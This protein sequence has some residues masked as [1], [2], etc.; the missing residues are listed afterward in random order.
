[1]PFA[2]RRHAAHTR[3]SL[4]R[5]HR[6]DDH[7]TTKPVSSSTAAPTAGTSAARNMQRGVKGQWPLSQPDPKDQWS[8][9]KDQWSRRQ[10]YPKGPM[11]P[12]ATK[13][14]G[15]AERTAF[16]NGHHA[17]PDSLWKTILSS[18]QGILG[19]RFQPGL[20]KFVARRACL[21]RLEIEFISKLL[22]APFV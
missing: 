4:S 17:G 10:P 20:S 16:I 6:L 2:G 13:P 14:R 18:A 8:P 7:P 19:Q 21:R 22:P 5:V 12:K 1:M 15:N 11:V 3:L 9:I